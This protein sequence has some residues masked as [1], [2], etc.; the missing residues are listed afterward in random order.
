MFQF[1]LTKNSTV[2]RCLN[3]VLFSNTQY[4]IT[5]IILRCIVYLRV[6]FYVLTFIW[7]EL[8][9]QD[10]SFGK[11]YSLVLMLLKNVTVTVTF[12]YCRIAKQT[13]TLF[14]NLK[15]PIDLKLCV[16][17]N[18]KSAFDIEYWTHVQNILHL[19]V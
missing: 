6:S 10:Y 19:N 9:Y 12:V 7:N 2:R 14:H 18:K 1:I 11:F 17:E 3:W 16:E 5:L 4:C 8:N 15:K 13:N